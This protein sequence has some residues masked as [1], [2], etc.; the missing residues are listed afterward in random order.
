M[1]IFKDS[2]VQALRGPLKWGDGTI[3]VALNIHPG[4]SVIINP[5]CSSGS[6][7]TTPIIS[8]IIEY[9][10]PVMGEWAFTFSH[11]KYCCFFIIIS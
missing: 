11:Y 8:K 6:I 2:T 10:Q 3:L 4:A 7:K 5:L 1:K 9:T